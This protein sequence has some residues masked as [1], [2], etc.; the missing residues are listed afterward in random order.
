MARK[1]GLLETMAYPALGR[2]AF[3]GALA[4]AVTCAM[5]LSAWRPLAAASEAPPVQFLQNLGD[6]AVTM[7]SN[8]S[9]SEAERE[10]KFRTLMN[11]GF[12]MTAIAR[13]ILGR[14]WR[15]ATE[16]QRTNFTKV[17]E[18]VMAARFAPFFSGSSQQSFDV[19]GVV[20]DAGKPDSPVVRSKIRLNDGKLA[21]VDWRLN[22]NDS[23]YRIIDVV[24][25]GVS[26]GITLRS[27][28]GSVLSRSGGNVDS[29]IEALRSKVK[30]ESA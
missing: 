8:P 29:L 13:F 1:S 12:D 3:L 28:Y 25:E 11:E 21:Q 14:Y 2:R 20:K 4:V 19:V 27:E 30:N 6:Q 18:E 9:L 24:T 16:E 17:F 5:P 7:L 22:E 10:S 23:K 26:M 15:T